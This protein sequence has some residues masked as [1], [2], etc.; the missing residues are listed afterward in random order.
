M[1]TT[2]P[3]RRG[4]GHPPRLHPYKGRM[5]SLKEIAALEG[6][7]LK[8][9]E[10]R[11]YRHGSCEPYQPKPNYKPITYN[12]ETKA[13]SQWARELGITPKVAYYRLKRYKSLDN[14]KL[15]DFKGRKL[16]FQQIADSLGISRNA[17][18]HRLRR[19]G[20]F[21]LP[22]REKKPPRPPKALRTHRNPARKPVAASKPLPPSPHT[23]RPK[24]LPKPP[25]I[26]QSIA[27]FLKSIASEPDD[28]KPLKD[29][30]NVG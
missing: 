14:P 2:P 30:L 26:R 6:K 16:T 15:H 24:T 11:L 17:A 4:K 12:G 20:T 10:H 1:Q 27:D 22:Q 5:L 21:E 9:I 13:I 25:R 18:Y 23:P 29:F 28:D 8:S 19:L 3:I 7:S